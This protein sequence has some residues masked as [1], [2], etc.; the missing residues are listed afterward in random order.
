MKTVT[1]DTGA[2][3]MKIIPRKFT[4]NLSIYFRDRLKNKGFNHAVSLIE[5]I[6]NKIQITYDPNVAEFIEGHTYDMTVYSSDYDLV[7]R[8]TVLCTNQTLS[9]AT[10]SDY[11][12]NK[13]EYKSVSSAGED[14]I[15]VE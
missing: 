3:T 6:Q 4:G 5:Y 2:K 11:T 13:D 8:D 14:Y 10:G 7:Y 9:P 12:L 15:I 1:T